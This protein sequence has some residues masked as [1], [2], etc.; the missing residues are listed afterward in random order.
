M[1][2]ALAGVAGYVRTPKTVGLAAAVVFA[3]LGSYATVAVLVPSQVAFLVIVVLGVSVPTTLDSYDLLPA[4]LGRTVLAVAVASLAH[5]A[6]FL[7]LF[8]AAAAV[9]GELTAGAVAFVIT[10]LA[11]AL[12]GR[13]L[14]G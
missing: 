3:I 8:V 11:G 4:S 2:S 9:T 14:Q 10:V 5:W 12:V 6:V 1:A 7:A 13:S